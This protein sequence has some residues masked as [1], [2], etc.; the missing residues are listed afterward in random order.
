MIWHESFI[1]QENLAFW[2]KRRDRCC[3][4]RLGFFNVLPG[5]EE[6]RLIA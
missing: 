2:Q 3:D 5:E 4:I 6:T 1:V